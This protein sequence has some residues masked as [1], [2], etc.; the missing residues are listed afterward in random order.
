MIPECLAV[1]LEAKL[2]LSPLSIAMLVALGLCVVIVWRYF[3]ARV[4]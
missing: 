3:K 1:S 2:I 4:R